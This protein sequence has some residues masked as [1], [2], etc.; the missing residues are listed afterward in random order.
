MMPVQLVGPES[1]PVVF[2]VVVVCAMYIC[3]P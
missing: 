2:C 1:E 3:C